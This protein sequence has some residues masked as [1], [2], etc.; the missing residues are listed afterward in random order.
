MINDTVP[1]GITEALS[2]FGLL[3]LV[4]DIVSVQ[5]DCR[6]VVHSCV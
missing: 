1:A 3:I 4:F 6:V 2:F 5:R